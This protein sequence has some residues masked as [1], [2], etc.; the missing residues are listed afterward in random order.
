MLS[1]K[2]ITPFCA[3]KGNLSSKEIKREELEH[4]YARISM[5]T[6]GMTKITELIAHQ[7]E[8]LS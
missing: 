6:T 1:E 8:F 5:A 3:V 7:L 2:P 4:R